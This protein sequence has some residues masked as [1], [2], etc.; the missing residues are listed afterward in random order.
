MKSCFNCKHIDVESFPETYDEP[1]Y[2][3]W[4]CGHD[5]VDEFSSDKPVPVINDDDDDVNN[6]RKLG[7]HF[8]KNCPGYEYFDWE[9]YRLKEA[10]KA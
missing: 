2:Y 8:A 1:E 5:D 6:D 9:D 10:A 3:S 7:Q 4:V